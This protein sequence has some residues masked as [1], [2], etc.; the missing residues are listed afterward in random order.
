LLVRGFG[1]GESSTASISSMQRLVGI[2][3]DRVTG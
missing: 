1:E 3:S 2:K